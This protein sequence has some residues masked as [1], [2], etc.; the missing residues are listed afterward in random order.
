MLYGSAT[1][2]LDPFI[3]AIAIEIR[4]KTNAKK[5]DFFG[6]LAGFGLLLGL[7]SGVLAAE[8]PAPHRSS[9]PS[10]TQ[11]QR[12]DQPLA[13]KVAVTLGGLGLMGLELWWFLFSKPKSQPV[14]DREGVKEI[15]D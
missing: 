14:V 7:I 11:F 12:I 3:K 6:T 5:S 13:N 2:D 4:S 10:F 1:F 8:M 15:T 9:Q